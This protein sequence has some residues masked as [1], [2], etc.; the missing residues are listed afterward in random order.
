MFAIKCVMKDQTYF[1][2]ATNLVLSMCYFG[3]LIRLFDQE[4]KD[5]SGQNF[6]SITNPIWLS[7]VTMTTVGYGDFYP[8]STPSRIAGIF[9]SFYGVYLVSLFVIALD[10]LLHFDEAEERSFD[11]IS[12]LETKEELKL[13]AVNVL[14]SAFK[15]R[16]AKKLHPDRKSFVLSKLKDF[17]KYLMNFQ[18]IAK[19]IRGNYGDTPSDLIRREIDDLKESIEELKLSLNAMNDHFGIEMVDTK[20]SSNVINNGSSD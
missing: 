12:R 15:H 6:D 11:L 19:S 17:R 8:K 20:G 3:Y 9:C 13:E 2:L 1:V 4:L 16:Q 7:I 18:K 14:T 10:N 5:A